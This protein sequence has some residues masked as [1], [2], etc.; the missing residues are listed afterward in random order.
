[1]IDLPSR[2]S[3]DSTRLPVLGCNFTAPC[4]H[5]QFADR[6]TEL[7]A[8]AKRFKSVRSTTRSALRAQSARW[9]T[10]SRHSFR[11][12]SLNE[13]Y[14]C[15]RFLTKSRF[16]LRYRRQIRRQAPALMLTCCVKTR[17]KW[18]WSEKPPASAI[19][20]RLLSVPRNMVIARSTR[21]CCSQV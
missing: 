1:M 17:V 6:L 19:S 14:G 8:H 15:W 13:S 9:T 5:Q 20:E 18:L 21:A 16:G 2:G 10:R 11:R 4:V 7:Q 12:L 3:S